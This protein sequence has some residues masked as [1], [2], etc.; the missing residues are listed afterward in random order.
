[1][2]DYPLTKLSYWQIFVTPLGLMHVYAISPTSL[3]TEMFCI[4]PGTS[5]RKPGEVVGYYRHRAVTLWAIL[6]IGILTC[7][8]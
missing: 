8:S 3:L 6:V 5:H 1:M 7:E 4:C 2:S